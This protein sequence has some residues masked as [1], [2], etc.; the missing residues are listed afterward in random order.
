MNL[1]IHLLVYVYHNAKIQYQNHLKETL[2]FFL[3]SFFSE[4]CLL[5]SVTFISGCPLMVPAIITNFLG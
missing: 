3:H 5:N 4:N 2:L 1:K